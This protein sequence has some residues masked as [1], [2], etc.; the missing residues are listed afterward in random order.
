MKFFV[1]IVLVLLLA[2]ICFAEPQELTSAKDRLSYSMGVATG[3]QLKRQSIDVNADM[4]SKGIKDVLSGGTLMMTEQE[5]QETLTNFQKDLAEKQ[6]TRQKELAEKNKKDG[7]AF[8]AENMKKEGVKTLPSGLQYKVI[9]EGT[10]R[11][12]KETDTV[13]THY[14]GSLIDGSEF[15]SSYKRGQPATFPVKGVIKGWT[16]A[17]QLMKEGSTWQLFVPADLAYG[18]RGAGSVI[19]PNATLI[20]EVELLSIKDAEEKKDAPASPH[21]NKPGNTKAAPKK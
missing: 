10:G 8:L 15:D 12:P 2:G 13:V 1:S 3:T 5:V 14:K 11:T 4:F 9:K 21:D 19:G 20:F 16:E 6:A 7:E 17:L 18:E